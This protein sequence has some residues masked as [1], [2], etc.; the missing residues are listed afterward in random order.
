M[1][2]HTNWILAS[3]SV[4][5]STDLNCSSEESSAMDLS[6]LWFVASRVWIYVKC[7]HILSIDW[8]TKSRICISVTIITKGGLS[9]ESCNR[10]VWQPSW[11]KLKLSQ[12]LSKLLL[13]FVSQLSFLLFK[14]SLFLL[15][16][17]FLLVNISSFNLLKIKVSILISLIIIITYLVAL[18]LWILFYINPSCL[19]PFIVLHYSFYKL[20]CMKLLRNNNARRRP[21]SLKITRLTSYCHTVGMSVQIYGLFVLEVILAWLHSIFRG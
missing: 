6:E 4:S 2:S 16:Q 20:A 7:L 8:S 9:K 10:W 5:W 19:F 17:L 3:Y 21:L 12:L 13:L 11:S 18:Q 14:N 1:A 15:S